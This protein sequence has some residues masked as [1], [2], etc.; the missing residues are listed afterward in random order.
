MMVVAVLLGS[1][2][3]ERMGDRVAKWAMAQLQARGHEAVLVDAAELELPLLDRLRLQNTQ[4]G[5]RNWR[6]WRICMLAQMGFAS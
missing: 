1:V 5:R 3:S 4:S 6:R 2:R